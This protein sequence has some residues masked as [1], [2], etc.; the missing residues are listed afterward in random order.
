[1]HTRLLNGTAELA[2]VFR[3]W[4]GRAEDIRVVTAW[5]TTDCAV[6]DCL[7]RGR[8]KIS[9]M[10]VGLDF[11]TTSPSFLDSF[12]SVIRIG[13]ARQ[14]GT[15]HPKLYLF[16]NGNKSCC[17]MGSSNFTSGGF[18]NNSEL[19]VCFEGGTSDPFFKQISAYID[20][21]EKD[22][23]PIT[24]AELSDYRD[25][26]EEFKASRKRL[27]KFRA[28]TA[29]EAKAKAAKAREAKGEEPPEQLNKTW[30]EF[31]RLILAPKRRKRIDGS[32][33]GNLD[34]LQT[35][36][37]C[38]ALFAQY[39][40]LAKMPLSERQF[41]GGTSSKGGWFGNMKGAGYFK[42]HLNGDPASLDA[43][44]DHIPPTGAVTKT[45]FDAFYAAYKWEG[46]GVANASRL[47]AMKRPDRF[48]CIDSK[49]RSGIAT[50][51]DVSASSLQSFGGYWNLLQ[52]IWRCPWWRTPRP[53][54]AI[55]RRIW[56]ARV[57]LLD[58]IYYKSN[59]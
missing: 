20:A 4:C 44:L 45:S 51:F 5:A 41:V 29:A 13:N 7:T 57:A 38:Q 55:E 56:N 46:A 28:S 53:Q 43:A 12:R 33:V 47:L 21:Q 35:A 31:V 37:R 6:C 24:K 2:Q 30:P 3:E 25:Q 18:G 9:T 34:Y 59:T 8:S 50:A 58:S 32:T 48:M 14:G 22:S 40:Q 26:F 11:Y 1:M 15:F 17:V 42:E 10:V 36:E 27:A 52:R 54:Q 16:E 23:D 49:N 39:G 19:N